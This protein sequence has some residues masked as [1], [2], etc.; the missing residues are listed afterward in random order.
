MKDQNNT[1]ASLQETFDKN[2]VEY[3]RITKTPFF[4]K[5]I[6]DIFRWFNITLDFINNQFNFIYFNI[7]IFNFDF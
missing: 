4:I 3:F 7:M 1:Y 6:C 5:Y 2:S